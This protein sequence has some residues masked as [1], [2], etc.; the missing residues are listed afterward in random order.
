MS[1]NTQKNYRIAFVGYDPEKALKGGG[2]QR[3]Y[4]KCDT[5]QFETREQQM[6]FF[7]NPEKIVEHLKGTD[8]IKMIMDSGA[9]GKKVV[10]VVELM[11]YLQGEQTRL[12]FD[13]RREIEVGVQTKK[14]ED[15]IFHGNISNASH[16]LIYVE[17]GKYGEEG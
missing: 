11:P 9:K 12:Y 16:K 3:P 2:S 6:E 17:G 15:K 13:E 7:D 1:E 14:K 5:L 8:I 4:F 10:P